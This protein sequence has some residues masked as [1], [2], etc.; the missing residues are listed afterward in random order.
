MFTRHTGAFL[1]RYKAAEIV[2]GRPNRAQR[3]HRLCAKGGKYHARDCKAVK[4]TRDEFMLMIPQNQHSSHHLQ[5]DIS[6]YRIVGT[7][8]PALLR[9]DMKRLIKEQPPELKWLLWTGNLR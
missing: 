9:R 3:S 1:V 4:L 8:S 6:A 7:T 5:Q 2:D